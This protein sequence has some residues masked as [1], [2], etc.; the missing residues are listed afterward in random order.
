MLRLPGIF[1]GSLKPLANDFLKDQSAA[2]LNWVINFIDVEQRTD[3]D[4]L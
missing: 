4:A 3:L 1:S 2:T